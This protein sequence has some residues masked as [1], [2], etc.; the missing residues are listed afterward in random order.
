[1]VLK[2]PAKGKPNCQKGIFLIFGSNELAL[3]IPF[4]KQVL[5]IYVLKQI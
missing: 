2:G 1:M 3:L 5:F 4:V